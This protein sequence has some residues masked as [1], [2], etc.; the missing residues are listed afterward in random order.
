MNPTLK[1]NTNEET[2]QAKCSRD[3]KVLHVS[4]AHSKRVW[5]FQFCSYSFTINILIVIKHN[6][7]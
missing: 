2:Q 7:F 6:L 1:K 4:V 5:S 3:H